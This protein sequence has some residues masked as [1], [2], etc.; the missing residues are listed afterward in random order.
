MRAS[1]AARVC[2][3]RSGGNLK[4]SSAR[5][6]CGS[7][8]WFFLAI[9]AKPIRLFQRA[10]TA[11][12]AR[13]PLATLALCSSSSS[14]SMSCTRVAPWNCQSLAQHAPPFEDRM[15]PPFGGSSRGGSSVETVAA[16][17]PCSHRST[18]WCKLSSAGKTSSSTAVRR[19][20]TQPDRSRGLAWG[21][22]DSSLSKI[23]AT[24][25]ASLTRKA[26]DEPRR[27]A[28]VTANCRNSDELDVSSSAKI[29]ALFLDATASCKARRRWVRSAETN[30]SGGK[31]TTRESSSESVSPPSDGFLFE[32]SFSAATATLSGEAVPIC[33]MTPIRTAWDDDPSRH[34]RSGSVFNLFKPWMGGSHT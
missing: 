14:F 13:G 1:S 21:F 15:P 5:S 6:L 34:A 30:A 11:P 7:A 32:I 25:S 22:A 26:D 24:S 28:S 18:S 31:T 27:H 20:A 4:K 33:E 10:Y 23:R 29:G 8:E 9:F 12:H 17:A 3:S 2:L 16:L 19:W